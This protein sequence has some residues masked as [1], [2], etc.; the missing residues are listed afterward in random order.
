ME[1]RRDIVLR[2]VPSTQ[3]YFPVYPTLSFLLLTTGSYLLLNV[4][5][6][7]LALESS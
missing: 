1:E 2:V 7:R 6:G 3:T 4:G 5:V